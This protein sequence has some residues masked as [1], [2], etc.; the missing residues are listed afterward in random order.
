MAHSNE[1]RLFIK[2]LPIKNLCRIFK[3]GKLKAGKNLN[4]V[5]AIVLYLVAVLLI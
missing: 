2:K 5:L 4:L 1:D 3:P